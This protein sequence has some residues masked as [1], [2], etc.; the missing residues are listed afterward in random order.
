MRKKM[1]TIG[2]ILHGMWMLLLLTTTPQRD[3]PLQVF[4]A[5]YGFTFLN[6]IAMVGHGLKYTRENKEKEKRF[7]IHR[8][9]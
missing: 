1:K 6:L 3:E 9:E 5:Y 2:I 7:K 8:N 4:I